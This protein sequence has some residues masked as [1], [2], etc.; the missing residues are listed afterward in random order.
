MYNFV[1]CSLEKYSTIED[2]LD[3]IIY[4]IISL[5]SLIY[6]TVC[7]VRVHYTIIESLDVLFAGCVKCGKSTP[8]HFA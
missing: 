5:I 6:N 7:R 8:T 4:F 1:L 3:I 2:I